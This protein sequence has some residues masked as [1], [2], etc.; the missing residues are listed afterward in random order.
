M[1]KKT[2]R[3]AK[4]NLRQ[5]LSEAVLD[6]LSQQLC[7]QFLY[8]FHATLLT[9]K[10]ISVFMSDEKRHEPNTHY[11]IK[12][13]EQ[14]FKKINITT[15]KVDFE[16]KTFQNILIDVDT[17]FE[18]NR[19]G[20]AEPT[21]GEILANDNLDLVIVPL[22]AFDAKGNRLGYG[23]GYYDRMLSQTNSNCLKIGYSLFD[24]ELEVLPA[25]KHD[26][27]LNA[28][29]CPHKVYFFE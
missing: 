23:G 6:D 14:K 13:I 18:L 9:V 22:L 7:H 21:S 25:E 10:T 16:T 2:I 12:A 3:Q 5:Q 8:H 19:Y 15:P 28:V 4:K 29:A 20:I 24:V 1:D 27:L 26:V 11:L 17:E